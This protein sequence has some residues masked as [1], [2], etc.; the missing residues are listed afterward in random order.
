MWSIKSVNFCRLSLDE[1][2]YIYVEKSVK[3]YRRNSVQNYTTPLL[4][5]GSQA[6][7]IFLSG[8]KSMEV[9][10]V[11]PTARFQRVTLV[12]SSVSPHLI[13]CFACFL[14]YYTNQFIVFPDYPLH[15]STVLA[16]VIVNPNQSNRFF[17]LQ[18]P[19]LSCPS[20]WSQSIPSSLAFA[21]VSLSCKWL[22]T[23]LFSGQTCS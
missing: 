4:S 22:V 10:C 23:A 9:L 13:S 17:L 14:K 15:T 19:S 20:L 12:S 11:C 21:Y 18:F 8:M 6:A 1:L 5:R 16:T 2:L 7:I 3:D